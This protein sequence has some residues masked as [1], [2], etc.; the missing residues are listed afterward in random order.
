MMAVPSLWVRC[1]VCHWECASQ[2]EG[3]D[4][5]DEFQI[6][7]L[8]YNTRHIYSIRLPIQKVPKI[9]A[10]ALLISITERYFQKIAQT[11]GVGRKYVNLAVSPPPHPK[12]DRVPLELI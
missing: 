9:H 1:A 11:L 2:S 3:F 8:Y 5:M 4:L 6:P 12:C 10:Q 7:P